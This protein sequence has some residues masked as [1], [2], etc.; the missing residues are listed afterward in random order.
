M[1]RQVI[2]RKDAGIEYTGYE[3]YPNIPEVP[4]IEEVS[5]LIYISSSRR[6]E[7]VLLSLAQV[8][9]KVPKLIY[10]GEGGKEETLL[11]AMIKGEGGDVYK[12]SKNYLT[13]ADTLDYLVMN[14]NNT[15]CDDRGVEKEL[16]A[17]EKGITGLMKEKEEMQLQVIRSEK[18]Q[19]SM[20]EAIR[21]IKKHM[22]KEKTTD[23]EVRCRFADVGKM[24]RDLRVS[25][26]ETIV[27]LEQMEEQ[28]LELT[29]NSSYRRTN[30]LSTYPQHTPQIMGKRVLYVR[31]HSSCA[32]LTTALIE[33]AEYLRIC[34]QLTCM[35]VMVLPTGERARLKYQNF[36]QVGVGNLRITR[37]KGIYKE[38]IVHEPKAQ[39]WN[40]LFQQEVEVMI[41]VDRLMD[42][43]ILKKVQG[44]VT[45]HAVQSIGDA[46]RFS[47]PAKDCIFSRRKCKGG[48]ITIKEIVNFGQ[49]RGEP[50]KRSSVYVQAM[51]KTVFYDL[52]KRLGLST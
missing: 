12:E 49:Y 9:L 23:Q 33:Y 30:E 7:E 22:E 29:T 47:L 38:C 39:V 42:R 31:E 24:L 50:T 41:I 19:E 21:K 37:G 48:G 26:K 34:H 17:L 6:Q 32:Y 15:A 8:S 5:T 16:E 43:P 28:L 45:L 36:P 25:H 18:W 10:L 3:I 13:D 20:G 11:I 51:K 46:Q 14:Y 35:L 52:D 2:I 44:M 4:K 40:A 1:S 27:A